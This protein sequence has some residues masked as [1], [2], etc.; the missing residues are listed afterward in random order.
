MTIVPAMAKPF[1]LRVRARRAT[2]WA[3]IP[4]A[5]AFIAWYWPRKRETDEE[6]A[7]EK[8]P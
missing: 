7:L 3:M 8:R 6:L 1:S 2:L 5:I 4:P